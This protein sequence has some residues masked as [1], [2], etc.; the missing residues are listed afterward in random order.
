MSDILQPKKVEM[1]DG[2]T[3]A[4]HA[5]TMEDLKKQVSVTIGVEEDE[6]ALI[7]QDGR[8]VRDTEETIETSLR[9]IPKPK[10]G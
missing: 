8:P 7:T 6:V 9:V 2:T 5:E 3:R 4:Y 1:P 10:W